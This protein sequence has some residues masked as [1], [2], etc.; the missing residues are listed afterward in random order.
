MQSSKFLLG[1]GVY[2]TIGRG[3]AFVQSDFEIV[4]SMVS[5]FAFLG[6]TEYVH[7]VMVVF[8]NGTHVD[9]CLGSGHGRTSDLRERD[10]ELETIQAF[11][12]ACTRIHSCID[13]GYSWGFLWGYRRKRFRRFQD[14]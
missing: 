5:Q 1:Q 3:S 14:R 2:R 10:L 4:G 9:L 13:E 12:L 7:K 6:F 8:R 11:E